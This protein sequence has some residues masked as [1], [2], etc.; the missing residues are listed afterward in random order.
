MRNQYIF[1]TFR[2][3]SSLRDFGKLIIHEFA[4]YAKGVQTATSLH[5]QEQFFTCNEM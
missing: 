4:I 3:K 1:K 2:I 5:N